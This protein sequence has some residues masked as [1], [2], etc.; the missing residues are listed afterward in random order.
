[1]RSHFVHGY[2]PEKLTQSETR[3]ENVTLRKSRSYYSYQPLGI[4]SGALCE[5]FCQLISSYV[6]SL[7][8]TLL[9]N[10]DFINVFISQHFKF[11]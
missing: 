4:K 9:I 6:R 7:R 1:M 11:K 3:F 10:R 5:T 8:Q 2:V